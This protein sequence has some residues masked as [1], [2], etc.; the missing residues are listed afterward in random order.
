MIK[1]NVL[2]TK[3]LLTLTILFMI[4]SL[5]FRVS[6]IN[7]LIIG[8]VLT[9]VSYFIGDRLILPRAGNL[10]A[11]IAD[12]GLAFIVIMIMLNV[13]VPSPFFPH[14]GAAASAAVGIT[15]GEIAVHYLFKPKNTADHSRYRYQ[16]KEAGYSTESSEEFPAVKKQ[17]KND[18]EDV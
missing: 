6:I 9:A 4:L 8:I 15:L 18:Q 17:G 10:I 1:S 14:A 11:S 12:L 5:F 7:T 2:L 13:L 16:P 3:F